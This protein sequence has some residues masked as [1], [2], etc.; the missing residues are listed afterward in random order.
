MRFKLRFIILLCFG[1]S[2]HSQGQTK[3]IAK[4]YECLNPYAAQNLMSG[5]SLKI[6]KTWCSYYG[7]HD[8]F[9]HS[10]KDGMTIK[11]ASMDN[12][13]MVFAYDREDYKSKDIEEALS[14]QI[15]DFGDDSEFKYVYIPDVHAIYGKYYIIKHKTMYNGKY[16]LNLK[17]LFNFEEQDY[18]IHYTVLEKHFDTYINEVVQ[19]MSTFKIK[20]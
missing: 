2:F 10:P 3:K 9:T 18:L 4:N 5:Y 13:I 6:P 1:M 11:Q 14:K 17:M 7:S 8:L 16:Y 20:A 19:V 15:V 12:N